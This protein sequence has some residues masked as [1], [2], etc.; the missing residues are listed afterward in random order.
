MGFKW[1]KWTSL[2]ATA[3]FSGSSF[4]WVRRLSTFYVQEVGG[5]LGSLGF[6]V[7]LRFGFG[8]SSVPLKDWG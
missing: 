2:A 1:S 3:A 4:T 6:R 5:C 7:G 8:T